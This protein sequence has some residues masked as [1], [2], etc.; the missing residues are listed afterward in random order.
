MKQSI[1]VAVV[2]A[3]AAAVGLAA[4]TEKAGPKEH[5][6]I[7]C[8]TKIPEPAL[9]Y[10]L[11]NVEGNGPKSVGIVGSMTN[12]AWYQ[13][14]KIQITGSA[15]PVKDAEQMEPAPP[16]APHYMNVTAVKVIAKTCK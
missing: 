1:G 2:M 3:F 8:L 7:G 9:P 6:M 11:D 15:V 4:Q 13:S 16:K 14:Q 5:S 12:M 10:R